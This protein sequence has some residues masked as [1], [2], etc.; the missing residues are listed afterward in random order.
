MLWYGK[1][2][3]FRYYKHNDPEVKNGLRKKGEAKEGEQM[4][5]QIIVTRKDITN[6]IKLSPMNNSRGKNAAHSAKLGQF[7]R[8]AFKQSG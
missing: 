6:K 1:L 7:D 2:E 4:H 3:H 8:K 5:I